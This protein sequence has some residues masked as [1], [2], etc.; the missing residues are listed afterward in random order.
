MLDCLVIGGGP[1]GLTAGLYLARF[2]RKFLVVDAG[3]PRAAAIPKTHNMPAFPDG[4]TGPDLLR[5]QR[6]ALLR[7]GPK[8]LVRGQV[9]ALTRCEDGF[10]AKIAGADQFET[11]AKRV[12]LATGAQDVELGLPDQK[13]AVRRGLV[14]YCPICD[15]FEAKD[16]KIGVIGFGARGLNE[17]L[18]IARTYGADVSLLTLGRPLDLTQGEQERCHR[19][20]VKIFRAPVRS[21]RVEGDR[22]AAINFG[23]F[24]EVVFDALYS[25]LGLEPRAELAK[26]LGAAHDHCGAVK[27]DARQQTSVRGLYAAGG[28]VEGLDQVVVAMGQAATAATHIHNHCEEGIDEV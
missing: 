11:R 10:A 7:Y 21:L 24:G 18:F 26:T 4:V 14:R 5:L 23:A 6:E 9:E 19:W 16:K 13:D 2:Q 27:V 17:A 12:L 3:A 25:A 20:G 1:A 8:S 15:G 22:V 28:V